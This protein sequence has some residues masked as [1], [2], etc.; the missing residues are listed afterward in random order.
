MCIR[1]TT[2]E[3]LFWHACE[4]FCMG[5]HSY[6]SSHYMLHRYTE[7][8]TLLKQVRLYEECLMRDREEMAMPGGVDITDHQQVFTALLEK[9]IL[10]Y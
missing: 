3:Y 4:C 10:S 1:L 2:L 8:P 7:N 5:C 9:V 6:S